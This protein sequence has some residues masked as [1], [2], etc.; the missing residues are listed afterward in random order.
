MN[1][2]DEIA[3]RA[4]AATE[5]LATRFRLWRWNRDLGPS[6]KPDPTVNE[7]DLPD[8][9]WVDYCEHWDPNDAIH[10]YASD[11]ALAEA[12]DAATQVMLTDIPD[13]VGLVRTLGEALRGLAEWVEV[14]PS[15][16]DGAV[17][18]ALALYD[19]WTT[20]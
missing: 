10:S 6:T 13:L 7:T 15:D 5:T 8:E 9:E 17:T 11:V 4:E 12:A 1:R 18:A 16:V 3:A 14:T 19:E 20:E 2:L